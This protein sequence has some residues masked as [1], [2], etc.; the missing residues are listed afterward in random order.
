MTLIKSVDPF[1]KSI[2]Y[3]NIFSLKMSDKFL[4]STKEDVLELVD[5]LNSI[6]S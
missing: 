6:D 4:Y 1:K 5:F 2:L 3:Y